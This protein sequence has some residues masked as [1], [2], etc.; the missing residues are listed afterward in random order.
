MISTY[1]LLLVVGALAF[2]IYDSGMLLFADDL[3]IERVGRRAFVRRGLAML[4][5]GKRPFI[6]NP[7]TPHRPLSLTTISA[8]LA[9]DRSHNNLQHYLD[10]LLPF[11]VLSV[12]LLVLFFPAL[13]AVLYFYGN[14]MLLLLWLALVYGNVIAIVYHLVRRRRV[15]E[16]SARKVAS[17]GF[18][19]VACA[20]FAINIVRKLTLRKDLGNLDRLK[21]SISDDDFRALVAEAST[22]VE[23]M[24]AE[25]GIA[26][27][28]PRALS[29]HEQRR[30]LGCS[31]D[32]N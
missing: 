4:V 22:C 19:C 21:S 8:L 26:A 30:L 16:L 27:T 1:E 25:I 20:P 13:P 11:K 12:A 10:A 24:I 18:E 9:N 14:G 32:N 17:I 6:P 3:V 2:Y 29:L 7:V 15:L 5:I 23:E 28:E 31:H